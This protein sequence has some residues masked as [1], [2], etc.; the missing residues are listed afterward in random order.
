MSPAQQAAWETLHAF[1]SAVSLCMITAL[2][3]TMLAGLMGR[4][5]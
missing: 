1:A 4:R 2:V 5:S 3:A